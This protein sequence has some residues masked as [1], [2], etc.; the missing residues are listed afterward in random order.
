MDAKTIRYTSA[1]TSS[2]QSVVVVIADSVYDAA[3]N[4]CRQ[5]GNTDYNRPPDKQMFDVD[6]F[7]DGNE[8]LVDFHN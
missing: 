8:R 1:T 2:V 7:F 4:N 6:M 3:E 5:F